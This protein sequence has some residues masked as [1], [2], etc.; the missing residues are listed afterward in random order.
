[1]TEELYGNE[2]QY[3]AGSFVDVADTSQAKF[4]D[5]PKWDG[6][7]LPTRDNCDLEN[8][9]Q[10][11][12]WQYTALPGVVGAPMVFPVEYWE[13]VSF[14]QWQLGSR[15]AEEPVKKYQVTQGSMLDPYSAAGKW[16][17]LDEADPETKTLADV[18]DEM[19]LAHQRELKQVVMDKMGFG[20]EQEE[21][22]KTVG[23][24]Q[25]VDLAA[26]LKINPDRLVMVLADFGL[27]VTPES[28]VERDVGERLAAHLGL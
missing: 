1:M 4:D 24:M 10:M 19:P 16:V 23:H 14:H 8:P 5:F 13:L 21:A 25:V 15:L 2:P 7:G 17:G 12:L 22:A 26:R 27:D 18:V 6:V 20:P 11:F 9:R 28:Y 3:D